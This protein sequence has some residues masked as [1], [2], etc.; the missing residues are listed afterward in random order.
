MAHEHC[1]LWLWTTNAFMRQ[2]F[3]CMDAWRFEQKTIL[4]WVKRHFGVGEWRGQTEHCL[5]AIRGKPVVRLTKQ[6]AA[7]F[8]PVREHSRKPQ[9]FYDLVEA[10]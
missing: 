4:T 8:A 7:L 5:L 9:E 1:I 6:A 10:L 2:A 3:A